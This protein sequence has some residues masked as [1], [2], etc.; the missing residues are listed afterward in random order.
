MNEFLPLI[1]PPPDK[2]PKLDFGATVRYWLLML[3]IIVGS[4]ILLP[5]P[6]KLVGSLGVW[7]FATIWMVMRTVRRQLGPALLQ[8]QGENNRWI[9]GLDLWSI[10]MFVTFGVMTVVIL[11][12][13]WFQ[14]KSGLFGGVVALGRV[15]LVPLVAI[16]LLRRWGVPHKPKSSISDWDREF[17]A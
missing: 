10:D 1:D 9:I 11:S 14:S 7:L 16:P 3:P 2:P 12:S 5:W 8:D 4:V 6:H 13:I 15:F 17:V